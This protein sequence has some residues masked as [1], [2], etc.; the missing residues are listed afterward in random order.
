[1]ASNH[2]T[3]TLVSMCK[4]VVHGATGNTDSYN[5]NYYSVVDHKGWIF[6]LSN[7]DINN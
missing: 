4:F 3:D 7:I 6:A 1:M 2:G 5:I